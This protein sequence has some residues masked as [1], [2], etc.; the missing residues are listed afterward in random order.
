MNIRLWFERLKERCHCKDVE[1][2]E[3]IILKWISEEQGELLWTGLISH[4]IWTSV[5]LL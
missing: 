3:R 1:I 4:R 2:S 5:G